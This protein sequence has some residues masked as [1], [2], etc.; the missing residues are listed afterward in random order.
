MSG[1]HVLGKKNSL[2][3]KKNNS[4]N[5]QK[6]EGFGPKWKS[7]PMYISEV[8]ERTRHKFIFLK[9]KSPLIIHNE[10]FLKEETINV[11]VNWIVSILM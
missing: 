1:D 5:K 2:Y 10:G 11:P 6:T 9:D 7:W 4:I 8:T 3:R